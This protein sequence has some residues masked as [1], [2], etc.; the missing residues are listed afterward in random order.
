MHEDGIGELLHLYVAEEP[1]D[2]HEVR[3]PGGVGADTTARSM[4]MLVCVPLK[5]AEHIIEQKGK[6]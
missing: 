4:D 1:E 2:L 3:L 6:S 5:S